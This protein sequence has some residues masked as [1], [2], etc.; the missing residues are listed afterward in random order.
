MFEKLIR[1]LKQSR[2]RV[3]EE[4]DKKIN[5]FN[6]PLAKEILWSPVSRGGHNFCTSRLHKNASGDYVYYPT[7]SAILFFLIFNLC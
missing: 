1:S 6:D 5:D 3:R 4:R 7:L 2:T